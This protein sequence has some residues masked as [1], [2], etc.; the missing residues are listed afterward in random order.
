M[1]F[2]IDG[3]RM[4]KGILQDRGE[5]KDCPLFQVK[6]PVDGN[7]SFYFCGHYNRIVILKEF[8]V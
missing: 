7:I 1:L 2:L 6:Y 8:C 3:D 4:L 5:D